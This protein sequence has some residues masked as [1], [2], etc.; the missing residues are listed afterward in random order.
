[1]VLFFPN[2]EAGTIKKVLNL[3]NEQGGRKLMPPFMFYNIEYSVFI[4]YN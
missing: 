2:R 3:N 1:M 4:V